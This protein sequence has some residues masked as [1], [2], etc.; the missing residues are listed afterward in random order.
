MAEDAGRAGR[1]K[2]PTGDLSTMTDEEINSCNADIASAFRSLRVRECR[3]P[4]GSRLWWGPGHFRPGS[5]SRGGAATRRGSSA[6]AVVAISDA[7]HEKG[8]ARF[9]HLTHFHP[10]IY[11]RKTRPRAKPARRGSRG[12]TSIICCRGWAQNKSQAK[13]AS[14][15]SETFRQRCRI[16]QCFTRWPES[17]PISL[18]ERRGVTQIAG[19][20]CT[21]L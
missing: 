17:V 18:S 16:M 2:R 13:A 6:R 19:S 1:C 7:L 3:G 9:S 8:E 10:D 12:R 4:I 20:E 15:G 11:S 14:D 21:A 5:I